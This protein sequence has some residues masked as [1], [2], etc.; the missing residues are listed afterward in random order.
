MEEALEEGID[1]EEELQ[2]LSPGEAAAIVSALN[3]LIYT[4][5][6][7]ADRFSMKRSTE[8]FEDTI[9][10]LVNLT[11]LETG[12]PNLD[13]GHTT[14]RSDLSAL[15]F[16]GYVA[17]EKFCADLH[18]PVERTVKRIFKFLLSGILMMPRG[19]SELEPRE[20]TVIRDHTLHFV[21]Y[22]V[23]RVTSRKS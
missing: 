1:E 7:F 12:V 11:Q 8:A 4:V 6:L 17:L 19:A 3:R 15:A 9:Q 13:F 14:R 23:S 2:Q 16:N 20:L 5:V 22:L 18:G 10:E 21:K